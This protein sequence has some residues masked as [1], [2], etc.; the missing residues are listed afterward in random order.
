MSMAKPRIDRDGAPSPLARIK[1]I[2]QRDPAEGERLQEMAAT[3]SA[4]AI[5]ADIEKRHKVHG[6]SAPRLSEFWRWLSE[7]QEIRLANESVQNIREIFNEVMPGAGAEETH[8]F[9][10][11]FL[12]AQGFGQKDHKLLKFVTVETRKAVE[13]ERERERFQFD[14]ARAALKCLPQLKAIAADKSMDEPARLNA[15]R[16]H[17]FG[18]T[19]E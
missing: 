9:L 17:L 2:V 10:V 11:R 12:S 18:V 1:R 14:A 15:A 16:K 8:K 4:E 7:Q 19:P 5:I 6:L 13:I 3:M